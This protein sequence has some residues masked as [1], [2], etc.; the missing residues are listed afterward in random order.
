[1]MVTSQTKPGIWIVDQELHRERP[2]QPI[3]YSRPTYY[4]LKHE[5]LDDSGITPKVEDTLNYL[6]L[7]N[8]EINHPGKI[9]E[10]L[11][12]HPDI[13]LVLSIISEDARLK[14]TA[15][16][17]LSLKLKQETYANDEYLILYVRQ[18]HYDGSVMKRIKQIR[19]EHGHIM[20]YSSGWLLLTTDFCP[21]GNTND[22]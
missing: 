2:D 1:M 4:K 16:S 10:Y 18:N 5:Q 22:V 14:F 20:S 3:A 7:L 21:M 11:I 15:A 6:K 19:N 9:R 12:Q 13:S 17:R 8:V